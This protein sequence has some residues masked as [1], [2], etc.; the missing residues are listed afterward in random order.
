LPRR[1][2]LFALAVG[3]AYSGSGRFPGYQAP[4]YFQ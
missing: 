1:P 3:H 2:A 4:C